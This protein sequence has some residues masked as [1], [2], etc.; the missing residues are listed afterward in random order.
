[1]VASI[2]RTAN[3]WLYADSDYVTEWWD[4]ISYNQ[5]M[6]LML[7]GLAFG[8]ILLRSSVKSAS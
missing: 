6:I 8:W 2:S 7:L 1:M 4:N 5:Y 3:K